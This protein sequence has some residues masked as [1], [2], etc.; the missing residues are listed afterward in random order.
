MREENGLK[1]KKFALA[2]VPL[3]IVAGAGYAKTGSSQAT[4]KVAVVTDIGGLN[5]KGFNHLANVGRLRA[6]SQL[7]VQT[8]VFVTG[9]AADRS[10]NLQSAAQSG[11]NLVF[12]VGFLMFDPLNSV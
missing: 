11:Y 5:D 2:A 4:L 3:T 6:Q 9:S 8:R 12:G 10:P 1:R 7:K